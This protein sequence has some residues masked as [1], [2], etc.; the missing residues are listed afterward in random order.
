MNT[1]VFCTIQR[2]IL[3]ILYWKGQGCHL[4]L[5]FWVSYCSGPHR[6][7][8]PWGWGDCSNIALGKISV[9]HLVVV[10]LV[11]A[12]IC[13]SHCTEYDHCNWSSHGPVKTP[14]HCQP[15]LSLYHRNH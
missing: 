4:E 2:Q 6:S 15:H 5:A 13:P 12:R 9:V 14:G 7:D 8:S 11:V 10:H 1:L 3:C